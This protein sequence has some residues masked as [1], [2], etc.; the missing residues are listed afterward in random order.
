MQKGIAANPRSAILAFEMG[1]LYYVRPGGRDLAGA[2]EYFER[3]ARLPGAPA[4][5]RRFAA[6]TRQ[7]S[8][9][10]AVALLLWQEVLRSSPNPLLR[11]MTEREIGSLQDALRTGRPDAAVR[12]LTTPQVIIR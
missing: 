11:E 2:A 6:F 1:F 8:G 4:P 9:D 10:L 5:A 3:S 12:R 7:H